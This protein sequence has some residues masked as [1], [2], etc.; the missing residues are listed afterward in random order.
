MSDKPKNSFTDRHMPKHQGLETLESLKARMNA[1]PS[2]FSAT[3]VAP[4]KPQSLLD[5]YFKDNL[6]LFVQDMHARPDHYDDRQKEV[7]QHLVG[8]GVGAAPTEAEKDEL[9][10]QYVRDTG[11]ARQSRDLVRKLTDAR[12]EQEKRDGD[13]TI[14]EDGRTLSDTMADGPQDKGIAG[15][16]FEQ[17][18]GD[19]VIV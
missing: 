8:M 3:V 7:I 18:N 13:A 6:E 9:A 1:P 5:F 16:V 19:K 15:F 14:M 17:Q 4:P 10:L 11:L 2:T 12:H